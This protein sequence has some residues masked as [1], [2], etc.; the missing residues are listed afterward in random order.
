V[1]RLGGGEVSGMGGGNGCLLGGGEGVRV[2]LYSLSSSVGWKVGDLAAS[3]ASLAFPFRVGSASIFR[4]R[5][6]FSCRSTSISSA[7]RF[8]RSA[9]SCCILVWPF[10]MAA[11]SG[12]MLVGPEGPASACL[13]TP[14]LLWVE[15]IFGEKQVLRCCLVPHGGCQLFL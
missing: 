7:L 10:R 8:F 5:Q 3:D 11:R 15:T 13:L 4:L 9:S 14:A 1:P 6:E 12:V 2:G